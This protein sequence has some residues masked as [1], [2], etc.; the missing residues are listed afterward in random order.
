V[1]PRRA[2]SGIGPCGTRR[3]PSRRLPG[4]CCG[5]AWQ[6]ERSVAGDGDLEVRTGEVFDALP[7][8]AAD[9]VVRVFVTAVASGACWTRR[10]TSVDLWSTTCVPS[11]TT[12]NASST[13]TAS[14]SSP[15]DGVMSQTVESGRARF[16][17]FNWPECR[18]APRT[19]RA[20][21]TASKS[22]RGA[23]SRSAD[24][25]GCRL[26]RCPRGGEGSAAVAVAGHGP[27]RCRKC[28]VPGSWGHQPPRWRRI[29]FQLER[30][31]LVAAIP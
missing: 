22:P 8:Q 17:R 12:L 30:W 7:Q 5:P 14:G 2:T 24:E 26:P 9:R 4:P 28:A 20:T 31:H 6:A 3:S 18:I 10:R 27:L 16:Q 19:G 1:R 13:A 11:C 15:P 23:A 21:S 25:C 29:C